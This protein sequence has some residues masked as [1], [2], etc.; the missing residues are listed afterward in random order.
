MNRSA[1]GHTL[2]VK[3]VEMNISTQRELR[4]QKMGAPKNKYRG[5]ETWPQRDLGEHDG[6]ILGEPY[7][8]MQRHALCLGN[9]VHCALFPCEYLTSSALWP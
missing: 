3:Q 5:R 9:S 2:Q 7:C 8:A 6:Q 1:G 4:L